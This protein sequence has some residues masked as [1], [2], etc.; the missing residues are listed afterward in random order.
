MQNSVTW[1][2]FCGYFF[3][4]DTNKE[5]ELEG[6]IRVGHCT[7]IIVP[8]IFHVCHFTKLVKVVIWWLIQ[9]YVQSTTSCGNLNYKME[10]DF[11]IEGFTWA[12]HGGMFCRPFTWLESTHFV[13][14]DCFIQYRCSKWLLKA[15]WNDKIVWSVQCKY[16]V[17]AS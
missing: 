15:M 10:T 9:R 1:C 13:C 8:C 3:H 6:S 16:M 4:F 2:F 12:F 14:S 5:L 11:V 7:S 17:P